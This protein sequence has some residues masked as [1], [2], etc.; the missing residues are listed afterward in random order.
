M[1][2]KL[3]REIYATAWFVDPVSFIS[4]TKTLEHVRSNNNSNI[5]DEKANSF[6][7]FD[8]TKAFD[9][10]RISR[11]EEV[12]EGSIAIY[13][14]D[15]VITK[16]GGYSH[17]GTKEIADQFRK[18]E[19]ND[20]IIGH[21]FFIESG[22]GSANAI[23][24]IRDV[25]N[26]GSRVKPL[27]TYAEDI[28]ASAAMYIASDSD[29]IF[30][31]SKDAII[32]SIGTMIEIEGYKSGTEDNTGK[33]HMRI[34]ASQSVNKNKEFE[35]AINDF[36][37]ELIKK[38]ILDPHCAEFIKDMKL[39][40]PNITD[41]QTT[42]KVFNA[43]NCVG[44][45][46][47]EIG[48]IEMAIEKIIDLSD[49]NSI[50]KNEVVMNKQKLKAEHPELYDEV[51]QSG[52]SAENARVSAWMTFN[53]VSPEK[54]KAGI[55]SK[56]EMSKAEELTFMRASQKL[57]MQSLLQ[58]DNAGS[59]SPDKEITKIKS[60]AEKEDAALNAALDAAGIEEG[61]NK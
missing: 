27:V 26:K 56:L 50:N 15:S 4:L 33:R 10:N 58:N 21:L 34:Y 30:A 61:G 22:G 53:D 49:N 44:T 9:A 12:P 52:V 19:S 46:I 39:N 29:Y 18:M 6:G 36:N 31:N 60:D 35:D 40:R 59:I 45:L 2:Y 17:Y 54:V 11:M 1:N 55:E 47:D 13:R 25:T 23:K 41:E 16:Y 14:F 38:T 7:I 5:V 8:K 20:N 48:T 43:E 51:F 42:G 3:A 57:D 28:M 37:Y 24:Y 32:G